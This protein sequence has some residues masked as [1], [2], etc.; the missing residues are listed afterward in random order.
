MS[1]IEFLHFQPGNSL[2]HRHDPRLKLLEISI[3]SILALSAPPIVMGL[4][5][6][7]IAILL[8]ISGTRISRMKKPLFFWL[9]MALTITISAGLNGGWPFSRSGLTSG[10]IRSARLLSVLMAGQLLSS[11]TDP[12]DLAA[13]IR[14][15][16]FFLPSSWAASISSAISLTL[17]F[18]PRILDETALIRDAAFSRGLGNRRSPLK[19]ALSL[20]LPMAEATLRRADITT[21]ALLSRCICENPTGPELH[22][23]FQDV[24]ISLAVIIPPVLLLFAANHCHISYITV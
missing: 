23:N 24:L 12:S 8:G 5:T 1:E 2:W 16:L 4:I 13:A 21:E 6:L 11:T 7:I 9:I 15:I 20:G 17:A 3:W 14:K 18:I 10:A 22:L 19:R